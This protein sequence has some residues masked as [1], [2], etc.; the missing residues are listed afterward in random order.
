MA[1]YGVQVPP[2]VLLD[3]LAMVTLRASET[4]RPLLQDRVGTVPQRQG[5][6]QPLADVAE[7]GQPV[8]AHRYARDRG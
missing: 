4:E 1:G 8:L 6:A 3:I 5:Q 2:P 7:A